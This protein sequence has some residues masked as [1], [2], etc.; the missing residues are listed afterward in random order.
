M[1]DFKYRPDVDGLRAVAVTLVLLFHAGLGFRGG[2]VGVDVFFVISG[3][4]ITGLILKE[5]DAETFS[6]K[7]FWL[8]RIRRI[9]P[10][11][12]AVVVVVLATGFLLLLPRDYED[13][14]NATVAQQFMLSNFYFWQNT[15]Y[16]DGPAELK[17]L[18]HTWSLAV[19]EQF[20]IG[21]PFLLLVLRRFGRRITFWSLLVLLVGSLA[22]SEYGVRHY[23]S[24]T[25]F[26]LPTRAWELLIGGLICF[27]PKPTRV[28][29]SCLTAVSW[30]ALALILW[31]GWCY[32]SATPFPGISACVPCVAAAALIYANSIRMTF[33]ARLLATKPFVFV[34]LISYSLYLWHW[35]VLAFGR[36]WSLVDGV[37]GGL[38]AVGISLV[39]AVASWRCIET[40]FRRR[41]PDSDVAEPAK[42]GR[43]VLTALVTSAITVSIASSIGALR[44][45]P[46]RLPEEARRLAEQDIAVPTHFASTST[47]L[48]LGQ[49]PIIGP[50]SNASLR[51][52]VWGDSHALAACDLLDELGNQYDVSGAV[53]ANTGHPPLL[54][55][56]KPNRGP[57]MREWN[58]L[59]LS[60]LEEL[61]VQHVFLVAR[62]TVLVEGQESGENDTLL[63]ENSSQ[64]PDRQRACQ[65]FRDSLRNTLDR[66]QRL[67]TRVWLM[68][69]VPLQNGDPLRNMVAN[70]V[71]ENGNIP[72]GSTA[73][74]YRARHAKANELIDEV[75]GQFSNVT[76]IDPR[77]TCFDARNLSKLGDGRGCFYADDD[78][79]SPLGADTLL[80]PLIEPI[81]ARE[82]AREDE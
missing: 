69:Q 24:P 49:V 50:R 8:R 39:L 21:Y 3:F 63:I 46:F 5:Q 70:A 31:A 51:F 42:K 74:A 67:N 22:L 75:A 55:V 47:T 58:D 2:F 66:L 62:W 80:K 44:G 52:A 48:Q 64:V 59:A 33:P 40:P 29:S 79:L 27:L 54:G 35:P 30:L 18:L 6:L 82:I 16:F 26:L 57:A 4:L 81:F 36:Y 13:L 45:L 43:V 77:A 61:R 60:T 25:F 1:I 11:A 53:V 19:E 10:A 28:W 65:L 68:K 72:S 73:N 23:P 20:Y 71:W 41:K 37:A 38:L 56:F 9:I 7:N 32:T 12:T 14:A 76:V 17:P 78:H 15:G 34:G